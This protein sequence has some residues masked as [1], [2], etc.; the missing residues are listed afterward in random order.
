MRV[1]EAEKL[2]AVAPEKFVEER[3]GLARRLREENRR[4]E[5]AVVAAFKKPTAVVLAVNR[6]ARDRPQ[7]AKDA[8]ELAERLARAQVS[9]GSEQYHGLLEKMAEASSLLGEVA[10][11]NLSKGKPASDALRRRAADH[12]RGALAGELTRELLARGALADELAAPG[13]DAFAGLPLPKSTARKRNVGADAARKRRDSEKELR[14]R[15]RD[16]QRAYAEAER[17]L[18]EATSERDRLAAERAKLETQL[19]ELHEV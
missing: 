17:R 11:A 15:M 1:N 19:E 2:L 14:K 8:V 4:D 9:G 18:A 10:I 5:A 16:V 7:A 3:D 13:F 12:I 6:A